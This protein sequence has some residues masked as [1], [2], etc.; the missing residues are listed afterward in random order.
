MLE[1]GIYGREIDWWGV[2]VAMYV[3]MC[4]RLPFYSSEDK[5]VLF[6]LIVKVYRSREW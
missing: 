4:G 1:Q 6:D 2:G 5:A 3:M